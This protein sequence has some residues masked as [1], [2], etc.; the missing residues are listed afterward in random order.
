M[1]RQ[2]TGAA[3][4]ALAVLCLGAPLAQAGDADASKAVTDPS[5]PASHDPIEGLNRAVFEVNGVFYEM[6]TPLVEAAPDPI[7]GL[8][9]AIGAAVAA[10]VRIV[11][12]MA[13]GDQSK[14]HLSDIARQNN[15]D[16]GFFVVLPFAG[17]TTSRDAVGTGVELVAN[18]VGQIIVMGAGSAANE[19]IEAEVKIRKLDGAL[20]KYAL[21][22]SATLQDR[23]CVVTQEADAPS[24][25]VTEEAA[26][27]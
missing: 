17:P 3:L 21:A 5:D 27:K 18:P 22:R 26:A 11:T 10:P 14:E 16:C 4:G 20:D 24:G 2:F 19:R 23:G 25:F 7:R 12:N 6:T 13:T 9:K 8:F 15:V 1:I